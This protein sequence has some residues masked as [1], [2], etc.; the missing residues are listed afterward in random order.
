M[1]TLIL[2]V[3]NAFR[4]FPSG[5]VVKNLPANTGDARDLR[6]IPGLGI[7]PGVGNGCSVQ[8]SSVAQL[9]PILCDPMDYSL[10]G[11]PVHHQLLEFVQTHIHQVGY[12]IQSSQ[13][14]SSPSPSAFNLSQHQGLFKWVSSL[15]Q[16][17]KVLELQLQHQSFQ[18]TVWKGSVDPLQYSCLENSMDRGA[19]WAAVHGIAPSLTQLSMC[20][21]T[22]VLNDSILNK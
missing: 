9:C 1:K 17:A 3:S 7:S 14:L 22:N 6:S 5:A 8:F 18:G 4:E 19:W 13:P 11:F 21:H 20:A 16:V 2:N 15:H 10:P 12:A